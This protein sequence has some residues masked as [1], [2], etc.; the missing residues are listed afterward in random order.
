MR[1]YVVLMGDPGVI[2][3]VHDS[4]EA[5][6]LEGASLVKL[7]PDKVDVTWQHARDANAYGEP[8]WT[9][10]QLP[11][12]EGWTSVVIEAHEV[13][14]LPEHLVTYQVERR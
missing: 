1:A 7:D 13:K 4:L 12:Y 9:L 14:S 2:W 8:T 3:S 11:D 5:A 6:M 10:Q